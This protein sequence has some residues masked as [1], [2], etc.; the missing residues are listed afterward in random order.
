MCTVFEFYA[1]TWFSLGAI[2]GSQRFQLTRPD[3]PVYNRS[4][5]CTG[6][7][8]HLRNCPS[9]EP[10]RTEPC[11]YRRNAYVV[12]QGEDDSFSICFITRNKYLIQ[13]VQLPWVTVK[14][15]IFVY[16]MDQMSVK[17]E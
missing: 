11:G 5:S 13:T 16:K 17:G 8:L 12:C 9:M 6:S 14:L 15:E 10:N 7:E 2:A 3:L 1:S 4:Y